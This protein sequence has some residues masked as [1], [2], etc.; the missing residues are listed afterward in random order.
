MVKVKL[1]DLYN[2]RFEEMESK[3]N[4]ELAKLESSGNSIKEVKIVG[5]SLQRCAI[6]VVYEE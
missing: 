6:F 4:N 3:V 2:V 5:D 1:I